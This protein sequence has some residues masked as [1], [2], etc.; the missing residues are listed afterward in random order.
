MRLLG[1]LAALDPHTYVVIN[2]YL[3]DSEK[4]AAAAT[5]AASTTGSGIGSLSESMISTAKQLHKG[6]DSSEEDAPVED[7]KGSGTISLEQN[8]KSGE[9]TVEQKV[10]V[11][12][13]SDNRHLPAHIFMYEQCATRSLASPKTSGNQRSTFTSGNA[14]AM[15]DN[16]VKPS[17]RSDEYCPQMAIG[18]LMN[19]LRDSSAAVHHPAVTKAI[20]EIFKSLGMRCV[21]FLGEILPFLF[22]MVRTCGRGLQESILQELSQLTSV[23]RHHLTPY[24]P[25][26]MDIIW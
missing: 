20:M 11:V 22:Q 26:L 16:S 7:N 13:D 21:T 23:V 25:S 15:S 4:K 14:A 6:S 2:E 8:D 3:R 19:M 5:R 17:P 12:L 9:T 24:L 18:A 10:G 1:V